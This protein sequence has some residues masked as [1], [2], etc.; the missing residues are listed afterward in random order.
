MTAV[1]PQIRPK[2]SIK[3]SFLTALGLLQ[4]LPAEEVPAQECF[5]DRHEVG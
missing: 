4:F 5:D 3:S 1:A 2:W